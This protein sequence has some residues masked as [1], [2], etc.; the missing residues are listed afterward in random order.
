V[1][2][3]QV[4][5]KLNGTHHLL[6]HADDMNLLRDNIN[7]IK[8]NTV[9]LIDVIKEVVL[10]MNIKKNCI[11]VVVSQPECRANPAHIN[12]KQVV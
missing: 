2:E 5:L 10:E 3:N 6:A 1:Q 8:E 11:N 4:S 7:V 9:A 12:S